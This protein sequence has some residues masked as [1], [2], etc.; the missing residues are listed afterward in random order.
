MKIIS[1]KNLCLV[2]IVYMTLSVSS[3][4][5]ATL[6]PEWVALSSSGSVGSA[7]AV[8]SGGN[9][10]ITGAVV[11]SGSSNDYH[12][13]KYDSNGN[14]LWEASYNGPGNADDHANALAIDGNGNVYVTGSSNTDAFNSDY[15]T[16]KYDSNGNQVWVA[17]YHGTGTGVDSAVAL[18]L[19]SHGNVYVTGASY[20]SNNNPDYA[21][22]K[23]DS[24]GNLLWVARYN[25]VPGAS[26]R[27]SALALD[28]DGNVYVTGSSY[29]I[30]S[31]QDYA[32]V[33]Y[34]S[35]GNQLWAARY[36]G[37]GNEDD[38]ATAL[39]V[40]VGGNV[41][42][43]GYIHGLG[44]GQDYA[45][46]KYDS[47]GNQLWVASYNGPANG[48]SAATALALDGIGNVYVT[49]ASYSSNNNSD[50]AT[51]KY[52]SN[53][54]QLWV[55]RY[56][57]SGNGNDTAYALGVDKGGNVYVTGGSPGLGRPD[58]YSATDYATVEYDSNGNQLWVGRYNGPGNG[59]DNA[60]AQVL[61]GDGNVYVTGRVATTYYAAA[62]IKY[63][64][65]NAISYTM[66]I[67][68][69]GSGSGT[70]SGAGSYAYG[71]TAT[72]TATANAGSTFAGW[73]GP[74]G[75]ECGT[76]SVLMDTDKS[77][78]A[79]F[80]LPTAMTTNLTL[81]GITATPSPAAVGETVTITATITNTGTADASNFEVDLYKN[82]ASPPPPG[83]VGD[84]TCSI[85]T[86]AAGVST[87]CAG[88][89][90]YDAVANDV[91]WAQVDTQ[92]TVAETDE[93]DNTDHLG[94]AVRL[95]DLQVNQLTVPTSNITV[96]QP[97][98]ISA[99]VE[100]ASAVDEFTPFEIDLYQNLAGSPGISQVGDVTCNVGFLAPKETTTCS[101]TVTYST[102]GTFNVWAQADTQN[103]VNEASE[104]NNLKGPASVTVAYPD[105]VISALRT[106]TTSASVGQSV[107]LIAYAHNGGG[108]AATSPFTIDI[109]QDSPTAPTPTQVGDI[110][111]TVN[112]LGTG[113]TVYCRGNVTYS[114]AGT[115]QVWA[116]VDRA[117]A[118]VESDETNNTAGPATITIH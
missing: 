32:T 11:V 21:T 47:N 60:V 8:D 25:D 84:I 94:I 34:D 63:S 41:Y 74:D 110:S 3:A 72:V 55:A 50:Y 82:L 83:Q 39:G 68:T 90:S 103:A 35:N 9:V 44:G 112:S 10:Y 69:A 24:N 48:G 85:G 1:V 4:W 114:A 105:L 40:D 46:V 100:N 62:T 71:Q 87:T 75:V 22:L 81:S 61:D 106:S 19:D 59:Y 98:T 77:C 30:G 45:T 86:L 80:N 111:C 76:G 118:D 96:D 109:Y 17:R 12:T 38:Y 58:A 31:Y 88:Q 2:G 23:Y 26:D 78:T 66:S 57:G 54:N 15:A 52:D 115:Y 102:T 36:N 97:V 101:A 73:S 56:N 5:A 27:A 51:L 113:R 93:T 6:T 53:G 104:S 79:T 64:Q 107:T 65:N 116:Q 99:V 33:K 14:Q 20:G 67:S 18:A 43:T 108:Y 28:S 91:M 13:V 70:V 7:I 42:V 16:V 95:P 89:V 117:N 49:G 92:N 37:P 29:G